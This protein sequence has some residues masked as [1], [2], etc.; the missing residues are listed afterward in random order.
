MER[1]VT[2]GF[3][4][5]AVLLCFPRKDRPWVC[6][7]AGVGALVIAYWDTAVALAIAFFQSKAGVWTL[8][9]LL[10][11]IGYCVLVGLNRLFSWFFGRSFN[12][13]YNREVHDGK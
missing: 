6:A 13:T 11:G 12:G 10:V 9:L 1:L 2:L 3:A 8:A 7:S 4:F 5:I